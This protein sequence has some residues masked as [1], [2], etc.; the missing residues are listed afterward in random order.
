[1]QQNVKQYC[2]PGFRHSELHTSAGECGAPAEKKGQPIG[3][4]LGKTEDNPTFLG[5]L[6]S[7]ELM[8]TAFNIPW[9]I[10]FTK[11][12]V[13][14]VWARLTV[15]TDNTSFVSILSYSCVP[16]SHNSLQQ[17]LTVIFRKISQTG[18]TTR[19]L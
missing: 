17:C 8:F 15:H 18:K 7:V 3:Q 12:G 11:S 2:S 16:Y 1:M 6:L 5:N 4:N 19:L 9:Q 14:C 10:L 13:F